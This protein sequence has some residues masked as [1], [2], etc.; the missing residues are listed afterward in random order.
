LVESS[1]KTWGRGKVKPKGGKPIKLKMVS[2]EAIAKAKGAKTLIAQAYSLTRP[3][4]KLYPSCH[5]G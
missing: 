5:K 1:S 3:K 2:K 4:V